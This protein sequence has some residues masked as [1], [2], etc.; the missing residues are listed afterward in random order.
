MECWALLALAR[1]C[2]NPAGTCR[3]S[4]GRAGICQANAAHAG[5]CQ[6]VGKAPAGT[7]PAFAGGKLAAPRPFDARES[8]R[9]ES[10]QTGDRPSSDP[11]A[12]SRWAGPT[13][14]V[15]LHCAFAAIAQRGDPLVVQPVF[16]RSTLPGST[17]RRS[18]NED[19]VC[20]D[21]STSAQPPARACGALTRN[22]DARALVTFLVRCRL[23][24]FCRATARWWSPPP[25]GGS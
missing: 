8:S 13:V 20:A 14:P 10:A 4:A 24:Q 2:Q 23:P 16:G 25:R 5:T 12:V 3:L 11:R 18:S 19:N 15:H 6:V 9:D 22:S 21:T 7:H 1:H 17:E